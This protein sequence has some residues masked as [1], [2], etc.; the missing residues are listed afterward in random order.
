MC[1]DLDLDLATHGAIEFFF[2]CVCSAPLTIR[3]RCLENNKILL[4]HVAR[5]HTH[6]HDGMT[7]IIF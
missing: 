4:V 7:G 5:R 1:V 2:L 3:S 6:M